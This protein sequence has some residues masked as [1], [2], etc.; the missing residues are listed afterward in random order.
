[1][2]FSIRTKFLIVMSGLLLICLS[3][4]LFMSITVFKTDKTQLVYDLNKSQVSNLST[5]INV[6]LKSVA[7]TLHLFAK[8]PDAEK[9]NLIGR[10]F[11]ADSEVIA[12]FSFASQGASIEN[13]YYKN[14]Y[15]ETYGVDQEELRKKVYTDR[16][17]IL[18]FSKEKEKIWNSSFEGFPPLLAFGKRVLVLNEEGRPV[19]QKILVAYLKVDSFLQS[20]SLLNISD[21]KITNQE[22]EVL[23]QKNV[24]KLVG[25]PKLTNSIL[26]KKAKSSSVKTSVTHIEENGKGWLSAYSKAY[27][28]QV[29]VF[30]RA[31]EEK[32]FQVVKSLTVRTLLFGSIVLTMVIIAA[33]LLSKTLT[34]NVALLAKRMKDASGGDLESPI[35]LK[36]RDETVSLGQSF[37]KMIADLKRSRDELEVMNREL[38]K[39]VRERTAEL[40]IQN[41]KVSEAQE[42]LIR[43]A[44]LA[45]MGEVA[46]RTAHEVLNPLTSLLTRVGLVEKKVSSH[47]KEPVEVLSELEEAWLEDYQDGGFPKLVE[48]WQA[49]SDIEK[50]KNIFL[51][52]MGNLNA[53]RTSL[54]GQIDEMTR[55]M[56]FIKEEGDRIGKII[57]GMRR[58]GN[59]NA[60]SKKENV[61]DLLNDCCYIMADLF[62]QQRF[63]IKKTFLDQDPIVIL[64]RDE[65]IQAVTNL[66][67][68]SLQ[69]LMEA[70]LTRGLKE[71]YWVQVSTF[72]EDDQLKI[73]IIDNGLGVSKENQKKLF[74]TNF[75]TKSSEEGTG[76]G[77]SI[78]RRFLRSYDGDIVFKPSSK[79]TIFEIQ[80]PLSECLERKDVA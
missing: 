2:T 24:E 76:L 66:M 17:K 41:Q 54:E 10:I 18:A 27:Q 65:F 35:A 70:R 16:D 58:L 51:E 7:E 13:A 45:S 59:T 64:D 44:R 33:F 61:H 6:R 25:R 40:E 62:D 46:G 38:D 28:D 22:G 71:E 31:P 53:I 39:K 60:V 75:T 52:D 67:R 26:F 5:E 8:L 74:T 56:K 57:H 55:D 77:L 19:S 9:K 3:F 73:Q 43:T 11:N 1:M 4:Y 47:Y 23:V 37:N 34:E 21:I 72:I 14:E 79:E 20:I 49:P 36:G 63:K 48:S 69:A 50:E 42:A 30:A 15:F 12:L 29:M 68:N 80:L 78:S 32:V